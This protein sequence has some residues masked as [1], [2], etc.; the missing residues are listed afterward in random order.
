MTTVDAQAYD[1]ASVRREFPIFS[2]EHNGKPLV[3]LD[4]AASSQKPRAVIESV[5]SFYAN[6]Y[7]NVHRGIYHLSHQATVAFES[8]RQKVQR[9]INAAEDKEI[10]FTRGT[11]DGMNLI[12]SS[13]ARA[14]LK[15]GDEVMISA[16]EHHSTIVPWQLVCEQYGASLKVIPMLDNGVLDLEAYAAL[17][18]S[19]TKIVSLIHVSNVLGTINPIKEMVEMAHQHEVPVVVDGAQAVAHGPVD[20]QALDCDFYLFSGHKVYGPSGTGVLYG[21]KS[22]LDAL[23][24]YQGGGDMISQVSFEKTEYNVLPY[25]FEAGTPNMAGVIGLGAAIDFFMGLCQQGLVSYENELFEMTYAELSNLPGV[26]CFGPVS[27]Q[28]AVISFTLDQA[29]PHDVATI[30]DQSGIAIRAGH[31]CAMPLMK[32]LGVSATCRVSLGVY[33]TPDDVRS[34]MAGLQQVLSIF[35]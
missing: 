13:F 1:V 28:A 4:T 33:N 15:P 9:F 17:F 18:S 25:K 3:Y 8:C 30:L 34:L 21:K 14:H 19:K 35:T 24:P 6:E 27:S 7:A 11:T 29:H 23:P 26:R 16:M 2:Q 22:W 5:Q 32:R 12:A 20:V 10:V 31:H